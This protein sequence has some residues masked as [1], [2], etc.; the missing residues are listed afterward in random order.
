VCQGLPSHGVGRSGATIGRA[1]SEYTF[2]AAKLPDPFAVP[3]EIPIAGVPQAARMCVDHAEQRQS[4]VMLPNRPAAERLRG[5]IEPHVRL[6][7]LAAGPGRERRQD[8]GAV[9]FP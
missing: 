5:C 8:E 6:T 4:P 7:G 3:A 9:A 2:A 1:D